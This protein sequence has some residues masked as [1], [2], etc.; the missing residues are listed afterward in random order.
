MA[1]N[2]RLEK[3]LNLVQK[4]RHITVA[5]LTERLDVSQVT[6]RKDLTRLEEQGLLIRSHGGASL[7][8]NS[9]SL[10]SVNSRSHLF[11]QEKDRI[12]DKA[13]ELIQ[14]DDSIC[15]DSGATN[16]LLGEKLS[17]LPIRVV[18]NSL[19]ILNTL[20][21]SRDV[22]LT[23]IGGNFRA[24][25]SSFIGPMAEEA[26]SQLQFDLAF[27]GTTGFTA[28]G[29]FLTQNTIE[30]HL[31]RAMLKAARRRIILADSSKYMARGFSKFANPDLV[32]ILITDKGFKERELFQSL[33]IDVL[34]V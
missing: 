24:S 2:P 25:A 28:E 6:I 27:I 13:L 15:I 33:G 18:T 12:T 30:G 26:V 20:T 7:A 4:F 14:E 34:L 5:E 1:H 17:H 23:A 32:D 29:D 19:H 22:T 10:P 3:I 8:Q 31:K 11:R 16:Q 9:N 21:P